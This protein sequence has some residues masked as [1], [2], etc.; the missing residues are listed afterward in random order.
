[1]STQTKA[2]EIFVNIYEYGDY[3][4]YI[5]ISTTGRQLLDQIASKLNLKEK[6]FFGLQF[7]D[8][9]G[10]ICWLN[11]DKKV[12]SNEFAKNSLIKLKLKVKYCPG[13]VVHDI[14]EEVTLNIFFDSIKESILN[15][16]IYCPTETCVLLASYATQAK[17]GDFADH[18][19]IRGFLIYDDLIPIRQI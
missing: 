12:S 3:S 4:F 7:Q 17:Y 15:A 11:V 1:M 14:I 10:L 8:K 16:E 6:W 5:N 19:P 9:N 18:I 2:T 13:D